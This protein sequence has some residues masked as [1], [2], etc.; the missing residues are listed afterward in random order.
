MADPPGSRPVVEGI[1]ESQEEEQ[2]RR[3]TATASA[4]PIL[5]LGAGGVHTCRRPPTR[6]P[7]WPSGRRLRRKPLDRRQTFT[8]GEIQ[9]PSGLACEKT[10][11]VASTGLSDPRDPVVPSQVR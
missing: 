11:P 8:E 1:Q 4:R 3:M 5:T 9:H 2:A 6:S 7:T 10:R